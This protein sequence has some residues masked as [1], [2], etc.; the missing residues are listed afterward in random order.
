MLEMLYNYWMREIKH[1]LNW[2]QVAIKHFIVNYICELRRTKFVETQEALTEQKDNLSI[3]KQ[4]SI[5][6][7]RILW[8][9]RSV[10]MNQYIQLTGDAINRT[11]R[12]KLFA[13]STTRAGTQQYAKYNLCQVKINSRIS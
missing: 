12:Y 10:D 7:R 5:K 11:I 13:P 3:N 9:R 2:H 6:L 4:T 1:A 8:A